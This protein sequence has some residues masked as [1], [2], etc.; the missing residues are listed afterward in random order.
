MLPALTLT[1]RLT[2]VRSQ[3]HTYNS[4]AYVIGNIRV[5]LDRRS[6]PS[7]FTVAA[8]NRLISPGSPLFVPGI[9]SAPRGRGGRGR[10][11]EGSKLRAG[12][13]S[14]GIHQ[15]NTRIAARRRVITRVQQSVRAADR[16]VRV[17]ALPSARTY[18]R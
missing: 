10:K 8:T 16:G 13:L 7:P 9:D 15:G 4:Q 5:P 18:G 6:L 17:D 12:Q 14:R 3:L 11:E 2:G 1:G